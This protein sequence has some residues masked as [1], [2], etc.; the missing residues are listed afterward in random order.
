M[1]LPFRNLLRF[2]GGSL[3]A[4]FVCL[5]FEQNAFYFFVECEVCLLIYGG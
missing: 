5:A 2:S 1:I 4:H 3:N